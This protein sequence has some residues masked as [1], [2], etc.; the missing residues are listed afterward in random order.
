MSD[1]SV[2]QRTTALRD[3]LQ[4]MGLSATDARL[5]LV[6]RHLELVEEANR[7]MNLTRIDA[8]SA[9]SM[10]VVD[11]LSCMPEVRGA[12]EGRLVDLGAGA[13]FP[14]IPLSVFAG[15]PVTLIEATGKKAR[16]LERVVAELRLDATVLAERAEEA[17][18]DHAGEFAVAAARA[19]SALPSL[20]ELAS[21]L[22]KL[23]GILVCLKGVPDQ[24]E[25]ERGRRAGSLCGMTEIGA[26]SVTVPGLDAGRTI[27]S[28]R[29]GGDAKVALP[30]RPGMAQ[31][32]PLA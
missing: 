12:P 26:R 25:L 30:R 16:F 4:S 6:I 3:S 17:A 20:V 32:Q 28:Y 24:D 5:G 15:R 22:L 9:I 19:L 11:S 7:E 10:H 13:G 27:V 18:H 14:G 8:A 23:G 31:R 2:E 29:K 1:Q 21:P